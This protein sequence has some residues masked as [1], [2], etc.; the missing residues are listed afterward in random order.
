MSEPESKSEASDPTWQVGDVI[1]GTYVLRSIREGAEPHYA[2]GGMGRVY[3]VL[4]SGWAMDLAAKVPHGESVR[5]TRARQVFIDECQT[6]VT[7]ALHPHVVT[8]YYV[9]RVDDIPVIFAEFV[10]GGSLKEW[11][12][13]RK[14]YKSGS[15]EA[16][17]RILDIAI[18][19]AWGLHHAHQQGLVHQDV[20]P[21]NI[22]MMLD[23]TAKITDFG[24]AKARASAGERSSTQ[25]DRGSILVSSG[26][27]TP[28]YC[29]PEQA[30]KQLLSRKTDMWSWAVSVLEMFVGE[31]TWPSGL[32]A[33][34]VLAQHRESASE[35]PD[36]PPM[37]SAVANVL[38]TCLRQNPEDRFA[39]MAA[40]AV[41]LR[42]LFPHVVG[43]E[44]KRAIPKMV[45]IRAS[46]LNNKAISLLD[47]GD[48]V[49][50]RRLLDQA[51][52][53]DPLHPEAAYNLGLLNWRSGA[54]TDDSLL[55]QLSTI[56][57]A[58]RNDWRPHLL[59]SLVHL[60][61][62]D[63]ASATEI[64]SRPPLSE[65]SDLDVRDALK[66][67][68][69]LSPIAGRGDRTISDHEGNLTDLTVTPD[70]RLLLS[71]AWDHSLRIWRLPDLQ[72]ERVLTGHTGAV[73]GVTVSADGRLALSGGL[74]GSVRLW[75]IATGKCLRVIEGK[76]GKIWAVAM[77]P[78]GG[79]GLV[80]TDDHNV[81]HYDLSTGCCV[82]SFIGHKGLVAGMQI[83]SDSKSL[84]TVSWDGTLVR[85]DFTS[86]KA[87]ML[88]DLYADK[89]CA[90][91]A[92]PDG[93]AALVG[94]EDMSL[95]LIDLDTGEKTGCFMGH[96]G[97][98]SAVAYSPNGL[99][100]L[101]ASSDKTI[102]LWEI[103]SGR[104]IRTFTGHEN[105]VN[106]LAF[107]P[108]GRTAYS[109]SSDNTIRAWDLTIG[110]ASPFAMS[111]PQQT[112][113]LVTFGDEYKT[114][115][116]Q[117]RRA[118][119]KGDIGSSL[120]LINEA[121]AIPEFAR[122]GKALDLLATAG[123]WARRTRLN[124]FFPHL[125][126]AQG[127]AKA[128]CLA[129]EL[130]D[131][132]AGIICGGGFH[133]KLWASGGH[134]IDRLALVGFGNGEVLLLN[135]DQH[136]SVGA[137]ENQSLC[138]WAVNFLPGGRRCLVVP[139]LKPARV[140]DVSSRQRLDADDIPPGWVENRALEQ[141]AEEDK[142]DWSPA[143]SGVI[144]TSWDGRWRL[145]SDKDDSLVLLDQKTNGE[146]PLA[147][148]S[149]NRVSCVAMLPDGRYGFSGGYDGVVRMWDL[150]NQKCVHL[151]EGHRSHVT[152]VACSSDGRWLVAG[153][154]DGSVRLWELVWDYE[155]PGWSEWCA[156]AQPQV[157][158]F[159]TR[160]G[161]TGL[162]DW[163]EELQ[164]RWLLDLQCVGYGWLRSEVA[165]QVIRHILPKAAV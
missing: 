104:C 77:S 145:S 157:D 29:S 119:E 43:Q 107:S 37:P 18:Q 12:D 35:H 133:E 95:R 26:G 62:G 159:V 130:N 15:Q 114:K 90:V 63:V 124:S 160:A 138:V 56:Q 134:H 141:D 72:C 150:P 103:A 89:L 126:Q 81:W 41:T 154:E 132:H 123:R 105:S 128:T 92:S 25:S 69:A 108:D 70:G 8:C 111:R 11:I 47:L 14:L 93:R 22:M 20:K 10:E 146:V 100:G 4:H 88:V 127:R 21:A 60:E 149:A 98:V 83:T 136:Q 9:R 27:M 131:R 68:H 140:Y 84:V 82:R 129:I 33:P 42:E 34:E 2:E 144:A 163:T 59:A 113:R 91:S 152:C 45:E 55:M 151:F 137:L 97:E 58:H 76:H 54:L 125:L 32:A 122:S 94:C 139:R 13:S 74:D 110:R 38:A 23:G 99:R 6:W 75:D 117:A 80:A 135:L 67:A 161:I 85:W 17:K 5:D 155:F 52:R 36:V 7:L 147:K 165:L 53:A 115:L 164:C 24:L 116:I 78:D 64:L 61:R 44:Q 3:R 46:G 28:A 16:L 87:I 153:G 73:V 48:E 109:G 106:A 102:R 156:E 65:R 49:K 120:R 112:P 148:G 101:S 79:S 30:N 142:L 96:G 57:T 1:L 66:R 121:R 118:I 162:S 40:I 86:G 158:A 39:D 50:A 143:S 71:S 31:V 51:V 19:A